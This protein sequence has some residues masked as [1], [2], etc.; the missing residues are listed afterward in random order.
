MG[1]NPGQ[2]LFQKSRKLSVAIMT[3]AEKQTK[4]NKASNLRCPVYKAFHFGQV[5]LCFSSLQAVGVWKQEPD[6]DGGSE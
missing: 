4:I 1:S 5:K 2:D 6:I 3:Q